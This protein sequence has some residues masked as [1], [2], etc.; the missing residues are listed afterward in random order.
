MNRNGPSLSSLRYT[1][2]ICCI[3]VYAI[4]LYT[5]YSMDIL[6]QRLTHVPNRTGLNGVRF[7]CTAPNCNL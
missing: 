1:F 2:N 5:I 7:H 6:E 4:C 3:F